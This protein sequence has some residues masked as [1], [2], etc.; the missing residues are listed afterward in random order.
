MWGVLGFALRFVPYIGTWISAT[1]PI[2]VSVALSPGWTEPMLVVGWY[3]FIEL[4]FN[5]VVEPLVY[6]STTGV[7]TIGVIFS[8]IFW[9]WLWGPMG[10]ILSMPMTVCLLVAARYVPQLKFLSVLLG[11]QPPATAA[12]RTY[13]RL[14]SFDY[15]EPLKLAHQKT[16]ETSLA[17]Y[18]DDVLIPTLSLI[19][20]DRH[21]DLLTD[22]QTSFVLEAAEDMVQELGEA[23][24]RR[25]DHERAKQIV[26][27]Q[28]APPTEPEL[29]T[30]RILCIPLRDIADEITCR[31]LA[32]LLTVQG[33][34][35]EV[36][37]A[38]SLT[39]ELVDQVADTDADVVVIS[40]LP[41]VEPRDSRLLW[42]R[43][44][45]RYPRLPIIVGFWTATTQRDSL[46]E[47]VE[48]AA[49]QVVTSFAEA[50]SG[51]RVMAARPKLQTKTA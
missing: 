17:T 33:F 25:L 40:V 29:P 35:V 21:A 50:I 48:D 11:D 43:L 39:S 24:Q 31:M 51:A 20:H 27:T 44:R 38:N 9:T 46:A 1:L 28:D 13:Q 41:P 10:L 45:S 26:K 32:Q 16:K 19:E 15:R 34:E 4:I 2:I 47:P 12:D 6:G 22:E 30:T 37:A 3:L 5:N 42:R 18:Y 23:E 14:M 36:G 7:S 49:S 8:A